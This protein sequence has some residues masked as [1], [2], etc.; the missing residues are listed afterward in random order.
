MPRGAGRIETASAD[1]NG[2]GDRS[3]PQGFRRGGVEEVEAVGA[4][5][6][7]AAACESLAGR[8]TKGMAASSGAMLEPWGSR[9]TR[10]KP[11]GISP[12]ES[13][14]IIMGQSKQGRLSVVAYTERSDTI[15]IISARKATRHERKVYAAEI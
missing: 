9:G 5:P 15:R 4:K 14:F 10:G 11:R 7:R 13:R 1:R 6:Q 3:G 8:A 12:E 2:D